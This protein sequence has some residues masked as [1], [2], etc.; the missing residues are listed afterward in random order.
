MFSPALP[1]YLA[2]DPTRLLPDTQYPVWNGGQQ[3][4]V[5][6][7][8]QAAEPY[9]SAFDDKSGAVL[10]VFGAR[11]TEVL[12]K[13]RPLSLS[14]YGFFALSGAFGCSVTHSLVIPLD[15]VKTRLQAEPSRYDGLVSGAIQ[16]SK[17]EGVLSLLAGWEPTLLG[18]LWYG[19]TVYPGYEF[20]KRLYLSLIPNESLR[21]LLVLLAGATATVFACF[22]VCPAEACR[23]RMV[24]DKEMRNCSLLQVVQRISRDEGVG[25][26]FD[27]LGTLLVRQVLFGMMKFLV[28]DYFADFVFDLMPALAEK[29]ETQLLV[30][31]VSGAVAGL[32][33]SIISQP[34]DTILTRMNQKQGRAFFLET[35][36]EILEEQG[37]QGFFAG[38]GSR[39]LWAACIISG[40]FFLYDAGSSGVDCA[41]QCRPAVVDVF[42]C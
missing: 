5:I 28:F 14:D 19:I 11:G 40:Q 42:L 25:V 18:Y 37:A 9:K 4:W 2:M 12:V 22:G 15:V 3:R 30:S 31:F 8:L 10:S 34:A 29:T 41:M 7:G 23:I 1:D 6:P 38:L 17:D 32:S 27:G 24:T 39:S 36:R 35:G 33:S 20:F 13:E 26:L 21:V 16:I